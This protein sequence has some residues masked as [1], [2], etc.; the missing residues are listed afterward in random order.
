MTDGPAVV[1]PGVLISGFISTGG[2]TAD[3][4]ERLLRGHFVAVVSPGC[5]TRS[6][7]EA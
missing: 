4:F 5:S 1:D 2:T 6:P 7:R 3:L